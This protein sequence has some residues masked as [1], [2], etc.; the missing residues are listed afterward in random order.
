MTSP[1]ARATAL[2][3]LLM[4]MLLAGFTQASTFTVTNTGNAGAGSLRQAIT[5][6]N[7]DNTATAALPHNILFAIAGAGV[8]TIAPTAQFPFITRSVVIDGYSQAGSSANSLAVGDDS[9]HL[10]EIDGTAAN[11]TNSLFSFE[12]GSGGSI[13]RGLVINRCLPRPTAVQVSTGNIK[14]E[15]NFFATNVAGTAG[16]GSGGV[17]I[18]TGFSRIPVLSSS[19]DRFLRRETSHPVLARASPSI[20]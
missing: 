1:L 14:L 3:M 11:I 18:S 7:A 2:L 13:L 4:S 17:G 5:D 9:V 12:S 19:A 10:I 16:L 8:K 20:T 15:G 6:A